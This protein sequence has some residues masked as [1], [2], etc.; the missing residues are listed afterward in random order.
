MLVVLMKETERQKKKKS[1]KVYFAC[2]ST[3][4]RLALWGQGGRKG[5][6]AAPLEARNMAP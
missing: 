6:G 1:L 3:L 2:D 5:G 4:E